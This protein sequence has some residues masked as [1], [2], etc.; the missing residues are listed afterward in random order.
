MLTENCILK[1]LDSNSCK[2]NSIG[3]ITDRLGKKFPVIK[4]GT[5]CRSVLLNSCPTLM[6]D[7]MEELKCYNIKMY[8]LNFTVESP[9]E[10]KKQFAK[11]I[12]AVKITDRKSL[13]ECTFIKEYFRFTLNIII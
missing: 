7:K 3:C 2:C 6:A 4:D 9:N 13:Q 11:P 5:N 10:I 12:F 1:N 8:N